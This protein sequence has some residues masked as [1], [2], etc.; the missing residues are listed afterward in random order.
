MSEILA[1]AIRRPGLAGW[2]PVDA[3]WFPRDWFDEAASQAQIVRHWQPGARAYRFAEGDVLCFKAATSMACDRLRP[4]P[5]VRQ[6]RALCSARLEPAEISALPLADLWLIRDARVQALNLAD[7]VELQP[8]QWFDIDHYGLLETYDCREVLP[9]PVLE[10]WEPQDIHQ[11]LGDVIGAPS[12]EREVMSKALKAAATK[13][14]ARA[15]AAGNS[16]ESREK[17]SAR[18]WLMP[19]LAVVAILVIYWENAVL[20]PPVLPGK[21]VPMRVAEASTGGGFDPVWFFLSAAVLTFILWLL[22]RALYGRIEIERQALAAQARK[23]Q[24]PAAAH[25]DAPAVPERRPRDR[26]KPSLWRQWLGRMAMASQL[27]TLLDRRQAAYMQRM[28]DMFEQ[29]DIAQALRHAIPLDSDQPSAGQAFGAPKPRD[30]LK[31]GQAR[32]PAL[33]FNLAEDFQ[34]HLRKLYRQTF[35]RLD[36][37]GRI[38][39]A[40]Y[41]LA[42]LLHVRPE[43]LDYLEKHQRYQQAAELALTWDSRSAVIVRLLCLAGDWQRALQVARRDRAFADAVLGLQA[44][45]PQTAERLRLEWADMLVGQGDWL[46]AVD[47]IWALPGERERARQW[48]L[49]AEAAGGTL[50]AAALVKRAVLLPDTLA[51]YESYIRALR[52]DIERADERAV[53]AIELIRV[54]PAS[55]SVQSIAAAMV[56]GV[57]ADHAGGHPGVTARDLGALVKLSGDGLLKLDMPSG[58]VP[59]NQSKALHPVI[60]LPHWSAPS[61]GSYA[62]YDAVSLRDDNYLVALGESGVAVVDRL[63]S[64][65]QRFIVPAS[66]LVIGNNCRVALALIQRDSVWRISKLD[67]VT[68]TATDLGVLPL[69]LFARRFDGVAW[70]VVTHGQ[71]RVVDIDRDF[72]TLWHVGDLPGPLVS[73]DVTA[74]H[75]YWLLRLPDNTLE[76]WT[77][78]LPERRLKSRDPQPKPIRAS[79]SWQLYCLGECIEC[80][81]ESPA[82]DQQ[83]LVINGQSRLRRFRFPEITEDTQARVYADEQ[84]L[85]M[86]FSVYG[87]RLR[88]HFAN[89]GLSQLCAILDWPEEQTLRVRQSGADWIFTD[90]QGRLFHVNVTTSRVRSLSIH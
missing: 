82:D 71:V 24:A 27:K 31:M 17:S 60:P 35:E 10:A 69:A 16:R 39:E 45:W 83:E 81:F 43:A 59:P 50:A 2:Q 15:A 90:R 85:V 47:V 6:G 61:P 53:L 8:G 34:A 29:G 4:W 7:G 73:L 5:L 68:G 28:L 75:E 3:L 80:W 12:A 32:G 49:N 67:L 20:S 21:A 46:D 23:H 76:Q 42:E 36:R 48:L 13:P 58:V 19:G 26:D 64:I 62:L 87:K 84:W 18:T 9:E 55:S 25:A 66:H 79:I 37:Q 77:Y 65:G 57:L 44:Q 54:S 41:V 89:R 74:D 11:V 86:G 52:D 70:T 1:M 78:G 30:E 88:F 72:A 40:V 38:E 56:H 14:K 51:V 33:T 63:G 22:R